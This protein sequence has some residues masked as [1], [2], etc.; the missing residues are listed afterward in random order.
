MANIASDDTLISGTESAD[1]LVA[2][3][4]NINRVTT[5]LAGAGDDVLI[6]DHGPVIVDAGAGNGTAATAITIDASSRWAT[7]LNPL[8]G[9]ETVPYTTIV[10]T[11]ANQN[12]YFKLTLA[13][14]AALTLDIDFAHAFNTFGGAQF[15]GPTWDAM[16]EIIGPTGAIVGLNDD[17]PL[18]NG[19]LGSG[20]PYDSYLTY[21][22][23]VDGVYL[24]KVGRYSGTAPIDAGL[25]YVLNVSATGHAAT[26]VV[27][28]SGDILFGEEGADYLLGNS[29]ADQLDGGAGNDLLL[30]RGGND[31][32]LGGIGN[33]TLSGDQ[34]DDSID[35]SAGRDTVNGDDGNDILL[36]GGG[37]DVVN[38]GSGDDRIDGGA[39]SDTLSGGTGQDSFVF[40]RILASDNI[41]RITDFV[42]ADDTILLFRPRF[43]GLTLGAL[44]DGA[45]AI[46]AAAG[47]ADD[48]IIYDSATGALSFDADGAGGVDAVQFAVLG[49]G[50][51]LTASDFLVI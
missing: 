49:T 1:I 38:G 6:A 17:S 35:G 23:S 39:L 32:I 3:G 41:D 10:G 20:H 42:V 46:G 48:R 7:G 16:V 36:G 2:W 28:P 4:R 29:G 13:A 5:I 51:A 9:D 37:S 12:D 27:A 8:V 47:D 43:A 19:G 40:S 26:A 34:G 33:D 24:I 14:G 44:A 31:R 21:T 15:G 30:G 45:F 11:G 22:A 18:T 25:N 50:L